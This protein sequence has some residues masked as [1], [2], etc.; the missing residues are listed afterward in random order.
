M[1][2]AAE[3]ESEEMEEKKILAKIFDRIDDDGS[4]A[5]TYDEL[6]EGARKVAEFR[7]WLRVLDIDAR[8]LE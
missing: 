7:H 4:G 3:L 5:V 1:T 2:R 6:R 8:D